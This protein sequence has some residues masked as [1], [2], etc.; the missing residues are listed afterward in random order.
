MSASCH[1]DHVPE[2][3][4]GNVHVGD[5]NT[6]N[7]QINN[8]GSSGPVLRGALQ[9]SANGGNITDARLSGAGVTA[10][11]FGPIGLGA[12]TGNLG[13]TFNATSAG[14][15]T[16]AWRISTSVFRCRVSDFFSFDGLRAPLFQRGASRNRILR[17][18]C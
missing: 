10:S 13:V 14:A 17:G 7:Y 8:T 5:T 1:L 11:N 9:T 2:R 3:D 6:R 4:V 16:S 12:A 15:L 18:M